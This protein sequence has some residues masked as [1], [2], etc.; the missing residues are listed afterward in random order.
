MKENQNTGSKKKRGMPDRYLF[1]GGEV[2][3]TV[4]I[5]DSQTVSGLPRGAAARSQGHCGRETMALVTECLRR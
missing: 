1:L 5:C 4:Y 3:E 2:I